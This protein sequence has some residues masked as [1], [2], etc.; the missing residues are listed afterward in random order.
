MAAHEPPAP[1]GAGLTKY[2]IR[3]RQY[4]PGK[5]ARTLGR[6]TLPLGAPLPR[7]AETIEFAGLSLTVFAVLWD[8]DRH[9]D[10][11]PPEAFA[12]SV[13]LRCH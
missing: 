10:T 12:V 3:I 4:P 9:D 13:E 6:V 1:S 2:A 8:L 11:T 5:A 7:A